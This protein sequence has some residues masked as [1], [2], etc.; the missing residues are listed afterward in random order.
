MTAENLHRQ[1]VEM[2]EHATECIAELSRLVRTQ[3]AR[4]EALALQS[5]VDGRSSW[6]Y[7]D[8]G[9]EAR[10]ADLRETVAAF[11]QVTWRG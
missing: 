3:Q 7:L 1:T 5:M 4:D 6:A 9:L 2:L 10:I 8:D 11:R